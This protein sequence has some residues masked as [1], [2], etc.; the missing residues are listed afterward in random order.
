MQQRKRDM[1]YH[2]SVIIYGP[3]DESG[4]C[5]CSNPDCDSRKLGIKHPCKEG[6]VIRCGHCNPRARCAHL[7]DPTGETRECES[8]NGRTRIKLFE[9]A[10]HGSCT[11]GKDVGEV[12]CPCDQF[13]AKPVS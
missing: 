4:F 13:A 9:C 2:G 8:C 7:G 5:V 12:V 11:I 6:D 3:P 10:V 1:H